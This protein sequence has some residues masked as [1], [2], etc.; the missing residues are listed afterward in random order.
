[1]SL[2]LTGREPLLGGEHT[3]GIGTGLEPMLGGDRLIAYYRKFFLSELFKPTTTHRRRATIGHWLDRFG[4]VRSGIDVD[5][6]GTPQIEWCPVSGG[7]VEIGEYEE[8]FSARRFWIAQYPVTWAQY[9][10]FLDADD[11][12]ADERWWDDHIRYRPEYDREVFLR[13]N[14]PAQEV[15]W[16]DAAA[17]CRW[18][19]HRTGIAARLPT[20]WEW[21]LAATDGSTGNNFPW[22]QLWEANHA[23]TREALLRY[24]TAVGMYPHAAAPSGAL[25]MSGNVLEW[26]Q[27]EYSEPHNVEPG[28]AKRANR[29]G[30]WFLVNDYARAVARTGHDPYLRYNSVGFRLAADDP[31]RKVEPVEVTIVEDAEPSEQVELQ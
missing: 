1:M 13:D 7:Y 22:G 29:G 12:H 28:P 4:D 8:L 27:N 25:D 15:S 5:E 20:E 26:C 3:V 11:G 30:S 18:F 9:R 16:Y 2:V 6:N 14:D 10:A 17:Y 31:F 23:N 24:A 21:E 19:T